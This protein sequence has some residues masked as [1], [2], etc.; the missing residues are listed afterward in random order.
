MKCY[1]LSEGDHEFYID[2]NITSRSAT[3]D[4][5]VK[6]PGRRIDRCDGDET[7]ENTVVGFYSVYRFNLENDNGMFTICLLFCFFADRGQQYFNPAASYSGVCTMEMTFWH[8]L[9]SIFQNVGISWIHG[10]T[11]L[12][13]YST[14]SGRLISVVKAWVKMQLIHHFQLQTD[15][16][17]A[18]CVPLST[19]KGMWCIVT[20]AINCSSTARQ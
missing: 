13:L 2:Q 14:V 10:Q 4:C 12:R 8:F 9:N 11:Y 6:C 1:C 16:K 15:G 19:T 18:N 20:A 3:A 7:K 17:L 5:K